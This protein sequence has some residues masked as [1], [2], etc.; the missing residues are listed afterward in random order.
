MLWNLC[1]GIY[2]AAV[3]GAGS[4]RNFGSSFSAT[5]PH[6]FVVAVQAIQ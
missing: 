6:N 5:K 2:A 1:Y 4:Y 3:D